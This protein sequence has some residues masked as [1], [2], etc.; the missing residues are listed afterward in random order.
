VKK[1]IG[2]FGQSTSP[3]RCVHGVPD[4]NTPVEIVFTTHRIYCPDCGT[5]SV[6]EIPFLAG[7]KSRVTRSLADTAIAFRGGMSITQ[8]AEVLHLSWE[9]AKTI[10]KN[11]LAKEFAYGA[12]LLLEDWCTTAR[13]TKVP[14]LESMARTIE[15]HMEGILGYWRH[16]K[17]CNSGAEGFNNKVRW[18]VKQAYGLRDR[19]Y[20]KLKIYALPDTETTRSI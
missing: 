15:D 6:E 17:A 19:E 8:I 2:D 16:G 11:W 14:E 9:Q 5:L 7:E 10:E 13:L 3:E 4:G 12:R 18:L 1:F 20:F